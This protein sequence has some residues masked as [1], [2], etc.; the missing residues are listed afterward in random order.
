MNYESGRYR[1]RAVNNNYEGVNN[2][3]EGVNNN[4]EGVNNNY[5]GVNNNYEGVNN[6]YEG[7]NNNYR[8]PN[9]EDDEEHVSEYY[10]V[11]K[12][13]NALPWTRPW[14]RKGRKRK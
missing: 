10:V 2:N 3:Y 4:Y 5:E 11:T 1:P 9:C 13:N 6:N 14:G 8:Y 7:V 12:P